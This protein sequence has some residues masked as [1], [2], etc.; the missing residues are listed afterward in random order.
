[1][2]PLKLMAFAYEARSGN[3]DRDPIIVE[4]LGDGSFRIEDGRHRAVACLI[5][6]RRDVLAQLT[7]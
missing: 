3:E 7:R 5:A 4:A 1:M 6:G 2:N